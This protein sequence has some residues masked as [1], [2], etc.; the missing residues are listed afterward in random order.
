MPQDLLAK[1]E[2]V[3]IIPGMKKAALGVGA[4]YGRGFVE[5]RNQSGS[6]WSAPA[7][8]R[9]EGGSVGLQIGA[10]ST[11]LVML[12]MNK[13]GM[14]KLLESKFTIGADASAAAGPVGRTASA[15]TD[16]QMGAEILAWSRSKGAF[17]GVSLNGATLRSDE[18]E[19]AELYGT[20]LSNREVLASDRQPPAAAQ[21]LI[22]QLDR[23]AARTPGSTS[24]AERSADRDK[25]RRTKPDKDKDK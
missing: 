12:V 11:D 4:Q 16:A 24:E 23:Y 1:A 25:D 10:S 22:S 13:R 8:V 18:D 5:C 6:G 19:N 2:C 7:A 21:Q 9:M 20:K 15:S 3:I 14:D 17:A